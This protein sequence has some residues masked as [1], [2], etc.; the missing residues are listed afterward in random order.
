MDVQWLWSF[1]VCIARMES[2]GSTLAVDIRD[3]GSTVMSSCDS[4]Q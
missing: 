3:A 4:F 2:Y 1:I